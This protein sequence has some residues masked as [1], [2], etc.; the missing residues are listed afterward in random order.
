MNRFFSIFNF[1]GVAAMGVLCCA[2]WQT[3]DRLENS[4]QRLDQTR[5]EQSAKIADQ[6]RTLKDDAADLDD[7]RQRLS[8]SESE[9]QTTIAQR[10]HFA[11]ED[12]QLKAALDKW[13]AAV[14]ERDAA[15]QKA[16]DLIQKLAAE[17]ND[18]IVKFNDLADKYN[19]LVKKETGND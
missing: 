5:I 14:K 13:I 7:L 18:A 17:R 16:G 2:Q 6:E 19:A 4:V 12:K 15:L 3:N 9:L 10:D 11:V 8:M 1:L